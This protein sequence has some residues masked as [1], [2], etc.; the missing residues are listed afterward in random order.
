MV[1]VILYPILYEENMFKGFNYINGKWCNGGDSFESRNPSTG[2]VLG[3]FPETN[4]NQV[5]DAIAA[6][7]KAFPAWKAL[8]R[9]KRAEYFDTL[10]QLFKEN[11]DVLVKTISLETGKNLNESHAEVLESLHMLQVVAGSGRTAYGNVLA[12]ELSTKDA[13]VIRK[14]KGVVGVISP[15]NFGLAIG[16]TWSSAPAIVEGNCVV[17]KPSEL[18]PRMAQI[19]A[20]LYRQAGFPFGVYN[21]VHGGE[22][23]GRAVVEGDVDVILFTGSA[24]VGKII[25]QHC[26][27]TW[28]KTCS[29]ELGSKSAVLVFEDGDLNMGLDAAIASAFKLSGQR[30]VSSGRVLIQRSVYREFVE[31]FVERASFVYPTDPFIENPGF[32]GPLISREHFL[33]VESFNNMARSD[34]EA[35]VRLEGVDSGNNFMNPFVYETEWRDVPYLKQEVFGPH[36][37]LVPFDTVDDAIRIYNDTEYGLA[38]GIITN[39]FRTMRRCR[40]ECNAGMI[41]LNGG[42]IAAE[43]QLPFGGI[44][45]SGNGHKSAAGTYKAVTDE[46]AVT[47][48]YEEGKISWCQG[49]K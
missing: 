15:W 2:E 37:A 31:K 12:S 49:M 48:N 21:L 35:I 13:Y 19:A 17:H 39:N 34:K 36:V 41:Y 40:D 32:Y 22:N 29:C 6:A 24:E 18:T 11:H 10:A 27:T 47:V 5:D 38:V 9:V 45:K 26:A 7:R 25:R 30:C 28:N 43:S 46:V 1:S 42:S 16:S 20:D 33:R 14:P 23:T 44:G 4:K 3:S 8:S